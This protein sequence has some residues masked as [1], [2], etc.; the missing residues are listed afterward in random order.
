MPLVFGT[1]DRDA[2]GEYNAAAFVDPV[3]G[4]LGAYRKTRLFPLTEYVPPVLDGATLRRLLPWAGTWRPG[5]GAR[6]FPL[7]LADGRE[8]PVAP[9]I[10]RDDLDPGLARQAAA[11]GARVLVGLS[12]DA[13][14]SRAPLGA[15]LHLQAA[16]MRS[17]ETRLPQVRAT[18]NGLSAVVDATGEVLARTRMGERTVLLADVRPRD[19]AA[20]PWM[21]FGDVLGPLSAAILLAWG[22]LAARGAWGPR[23]GASVA[24]DAT[25]A[26]AA[27]R[28]LLLRPWQRGLISGLR[29]VS[30]IAVLGL[31]VLAVASHDAPGM[32][33]QLRLFAAAVLLP[34]LLADGLASHATATLRRNAAHL[35]LDA[36]RHRIEIDPARIVALRPWRLPWPQPGFDVQLESGRRWTHG[37]ALR[38]AGA[39]LRRSGLPVSPIPPRRAGLLDALDVAPR[40][41]DGAAVKFVLFPLLPA[42]PAF[43]LHQLIAYGSPFGEYYTFGARAYLTT[44]GLWWASWA[45]ALVLVAGALR[46]LVELAA[47]AAVAL[48]PQHAAA[49]RQGL[50]GA[51]RIAY[52]VGVPG[53]L[54][55]RLLAG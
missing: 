12:N 28:V 17:V 3:R 29:G 42:L 21:R 19:A 9:L 10:C 20:T 43:R 38:G 52:F 24:V 16:A 46:A 23:R 50:L 53:W 25:A 1:Y 41:M 49:V 44:L 34:E 51:A 11:L 48:G 5:D 40:W 45:V 7:L 31:G 47:M 39:W 33:A 32:L 55:W 54:A 6:V 13:W 36:R 30:R 26:Q 15:R 8:V 18:T 27:H 14:F 35:V 4:P 37:I 2:D 22:L